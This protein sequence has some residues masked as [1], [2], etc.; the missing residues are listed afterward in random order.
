MTK[1]LKTTYLFFAIFILIA[2]CTLIIFNPKTK[3]EILNNRENSYIGLKTSQN[4]APFI[5]GT[6]TGPQTLDPVN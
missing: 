3:P 4:D 6:G 2:S 1:F 5:V